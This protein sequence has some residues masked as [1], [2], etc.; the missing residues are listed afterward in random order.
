MQFISLNQ[1]LYL[2]KKIIDS[3]GGTKGIRD[4]KM[5]EASLVQPYMIFDGKDL[6]KTIIDKAAALG[7]SIIMNHPLLMVIK[8]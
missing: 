8:E 1:I 5:L 4:F 6:Y 3:S 7:F 2:Y